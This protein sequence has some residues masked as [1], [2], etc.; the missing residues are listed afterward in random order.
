MI[1]QVSLRRCACCTG[2]VAIL[3]AV[4]QGSTQAQLRI[5]N[6]NTLDKPTSATPGSDVEIILDAIGN[7]STNG[8]AKRV[9]IITLQEQAYLGGSLDNN[10]SRYI[11]DTLNA[12]YGVS[13][14]TY[15]LGFDELGFVYDSSTVDFISATTINTA[16]PRDTYLLQFRPEGYTSSDANVY[17]YSAHFKAGTSSSDESTRNIEGLF[18]SN[19]ADGLPEGTNIVMTGDFNFYSHTEP[20]FLQLTGA[21]NGQVNDPLALPTWTAGVFPQHMTQ[22]TRTTS[23]GGGAGGGMDDRF[24][25]QWL[26]DELLDGEGISYIGPT[27]SGGGALD[28]S[29]QA[30]GNDGVSTNQAINNIIAG[31]S[32]SAAVLNALHDFSDHLPVVADYQ[33]PAVMDAFFT[34]TIPASVDLGAGVPLAMMVE[35]IADVLVA[36]GADELDYTLTSTGDGILAFI[37]DTFG[38]DIALGGGNSHTAVLDTTTVGIK[39]G[40]IIFE[41]TSLAA[42]NS[43]IEIPYSFEVVDPTIPG[44]YDDDGFVGQSD[45]NLVLLNWGAAATPPGWIN[46]P[47]V[48]G[49][50]SQNE[51]NGVLLNWGNGTPAIV[52]SAIVPEPTSM[53]LVLGVLFALPYRRPVRA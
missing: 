14:Y 45:L 18:L 7:T 46:E 48:D 5:V 34:S 12:L 31:R 43:F 3:L 36:A 49:Q 33:L 17:L 4:L 24:D 32:Q 37:G 8:I 30:F 44:D 28:H 42:E 25:A 10:T 6:Y 29:Y 23:F 21:G 19:H 20:G 1:D 40:S 39:S 16:G 53:V 41:S 35:N 11:A 22:S 51:L 50:V 52:A 27:S 13:S 15:S 2:F 9:D 26:S 38:T 47:V